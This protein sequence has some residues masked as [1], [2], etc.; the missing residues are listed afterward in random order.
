MLCDACDE[1]RHWECSLQTSCECDCDPFCGDPEFDSDFE[2]MPDDYDTC[3]D[4][5]ESE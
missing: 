5:E 2:S 1:E 4:E 3:D